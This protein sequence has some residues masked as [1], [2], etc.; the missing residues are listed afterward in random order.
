MAVTHP[1]ARRNGIADH[2]VD[3][4][5]GGNLEFQTSGSAEVATCTF[6]TPAFGAASSGVAT[7]NA[8]TKDSSATGGTT[9]KAELQN[10]GSTA[11]VLCSVTSTGGGGDIELS[12]N[13]VGAGQEVDIT[14]LTYTAPA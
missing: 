9:T 3:Q 1:T 6:G 11:Q 5:D 8:I 13:V 4:L 12:N 7:A 2:V 14:S 10:S